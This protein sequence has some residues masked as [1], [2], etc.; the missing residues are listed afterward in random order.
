[1]AFIG[2]SMAIG[3]GVAI[4]TNKEATR[5]EA[6]DELSYTLTAKSN[7]T[8]SDS[9]TDVAST[10]SSLFTDVTNIT[11][12]SGSKVYQGA[13]SA[14]ALKFGSSSAKGSLTI[15]LASGGQKKA[16]K[17]TFSIAAA[18]DTSKKVKLS[19]NGA[20]SGTGYSLITY[21]STAKS[22]ADYEVAWDGSTALTSIKVEA[23]NVSSN[24][25]YLKN[26]KVY[27]AP[28]SYTVSFAVN[29]AGYGTVS[30]S[31]ITNVPSGSSITTSSNTVT[32][33][34][35]TVTATPAANTAQYT[36]AFTGWSNNTGTV[37]AARTITA[38]FSRT[39]NTYSV[40]GTITNGSLS[41]TASVAYGSALNISINPNDGYTYP[42]TLTSVTMGGSAY[43]GYTYNS[44]T[45]AF[46]IASVTGAVVINATCPSSSATEYIFD[47][48]L[49]HC[50]I[51]NAPESMWSDDIVELT[52]TPDDHYKL[53]AEDA[54]KVSVTGAVEWHYDEDDGTITID[55]ADDDL[56][57]TV[58]CVAKETYDVTLSLTNVTKSSGPSGTDAV[59]EDEEV[60]IVFA[61]ST[62]YALPST[63][64]VTMGGNTLVVNDN[65]T[66][67]KNTG[68]LYLLELTGDLTV[69]IV[70]EAKALSSIS[71]SSNSGDYTLGDT[72]V[73]P[74]VTAT[75]NTGNED[76]T[77][78]ATASGSGLVNGVFTTTGNGK[79]ITI[80]YTYGNVT[81]TASYTANVTAKS[82][83]SARYEKVTSTQGIVSGGKYLIVNETATVAF[84]GT[85]DTASNTVSYTA[86]GSYISTAS[87]LTPCEVTITYDSQNSRY[88]IVNS[89]GKYIGR[90]S[91][92][93]GLDL[94][95]SA[96]YDTISFDS[97][98]VVIRGLN[99]STGTYY[100]RYN[101]GV[102]D[103]RF[104]YYNNTQQAIQLYRYVA[105][106]DKDLKWI[107]A[108]VKSGTYYQGSTVTA[109]SF[110]VTAHYDDGSTSTPTSDIT[111]TNGY[112]ANIGANSVTL[113]YG[114]KSCV[115]SVTAVEQTATLTG[116]SWAQG[117]LTIIDG[118]DIDFS[119]L[120]TITATYDVG[121]SQTKAIAS[122]TVSTFTKSGDVYTKVSDIDDGDAITSTSHGKYLGV[123]YTEKAVTK[124][125]YS[126]APIYVVEEIDDVYTQVETWTYTNLATSL[127]DGDRVVMVA[128]DFAFELT[129][130]DTDASTNHGVGS[131]YTTSVSGTYALTVEH[132]SDNVYAFKDSSN[133]YLR[134]SSGN[135]LTLS[136]AN[137]DVSQDSNS[138]W[139]VTFDGTDAQLVN[140]GTLD[141]ARTLAWNNTSNSQR[142]ANY[143]NS[144]ITGVS[145]D[146]YS[147]VSFYIGVQS[148]TP[149]GDSIANTN[150]V[151]QKAVLEYAAHFND[152]MD[153]VNSGSTTNVSG[154]WDDLSD[155]FDAALAEFTG[156]DLN[157]FKALFANAYAV[158]GGDT[159][160]DMLARY[161]YICAKYK[162][163]DFL[164][165]IDRPPVPQ[166]TNPILSI[167][168]ADSANLA[169]VMIVISMIT[170][171]AIGGYFFLKKRKEER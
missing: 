90:T 146:N 67:T 162:L 63:I 107:T 96:I 77:S 13:S 15:N 153:C 143:K 79:T 135:S 94:S 70:G 149:T 16:T 56:T 159:L 72:F 168:K 5:A 73:M 120:G 167:F 3:V 81:R 137:I 157:H 18:N 152:V 33:N 111:V 130:V 163:D 164:A 71:I 35:T 17:V 161:N 87:A 117:E 102:S 154:K 129:S 14:A 127:N 47:Y 37:T 25:F 10:K 95:T 103:N 147:Y 92:S 51:T 115:V 74:T 50:S 122:C 142:F 23:Q 166:Q 30:Q 170:A 24:R 38:N 112:L 42:S 125:A 85:A 113:T 105:A 151:I 88:S 119:E 8:D 98:N 99:G 76:V 68:T 29:T 80:S 126:S 32:I 104:R 45:G 89:A 150:A 60:T 93:N 165:D 121:P 12:T 75:F 9:S 138:T 78:Q 110:T 108:E 69:T 27:V 114:G 26:I 133:K 49:T 144:T 83:H 169:T 55:G 132:V 58:E 160:Q 91:S 57:V 118:Q 2:A 100:L 19:L 62:N 54:D 131:E 155:D 61:A 106:V 41:S 40:G 140:Q 65:Y 139:A 53:P 22:F 44:S 116:L 48:D 145:G 97:N 128:S 148:Y 34:G 36:Y 124:V 123:T 28:P 31:S 82:T 4:G 66:W 52:I 156:D 101:N 141:E 59:E 43:A 46:S 64:T 171:T 39:T 21:G 134:W 20:T 1:M 11:S 7:S 6:A 136:A 84:N 109:S 86:D 158:E